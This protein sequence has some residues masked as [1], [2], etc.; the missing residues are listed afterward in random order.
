MAASLDDPPTPYV[1]RPV[2]PRDLRHLAAVEDAGGVLFTGL[3]GDLDGDALVAPA[4]SGGSRADQ[5]GFLLVAAAPGEVPVGFV[6]VL[7][8][9]GEWHLEQVAVRP[10]EG[11]RGIG[12]ALV[13]A[14]MEEARWRGADRLSLC[15]YRDVAWNGPFYARLGFTEVA[16]PRPWQQELRAHERALGLDRH[17]V[18]VLMDVGLRRRP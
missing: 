3:W 16:R 18:R 10:E 5:P 13:L 7:E 1:V 17:G 11:R 4:P 6:H 15:T 8:I 12:T 2:A 14:A 9:E